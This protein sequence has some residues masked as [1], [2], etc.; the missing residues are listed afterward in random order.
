MAKLPWTI[1]VL[2]AGLGVLV[3]G[4]FEATRAY[5]HW[6]GPDPLA[7]EDIE[8]GVLPPR[9]FV[10]VSDVQLVFVMAVEDD[11][12]VDPG[13]P[14]GEPEYYVPAVGA[15]RNVLR[16]VRSL[17]PDASLAL[18]DV[19]L[20]VK[21]DSPPADEPAVDTYESVTGSMSIGIP[22]TGVDDLTANFPHTNLRN[23]PVLVIEPHRSMSRAMAFAGA[24]AALLIAG[25]F[26]TL[27]SD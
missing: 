15:D 6:K 23:V 22:A 16:E 3:Y 13:D 27:R 12:F 8:H 24:G 17:H 21:W 7:L 5:E 20:F 14:G 19:K 2:I 26:G 4:L 9:R 25:L 11:R 10:T 18:Y 1:W